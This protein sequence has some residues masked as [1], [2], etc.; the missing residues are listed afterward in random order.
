MKKNLNLT[1]LFQYNQNW[2][3]LSIERHA[4]AIKQNS[5]S[6]CHR[7]DKLLS[8]PHF[9]LTFEKNN[10]CFCEVTFDTESCCA[11]IQNIIF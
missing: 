8:Q 7:H 9:C 2:P 11:I 3:T 10:S 6:Q 4:A 1:T 5:Q